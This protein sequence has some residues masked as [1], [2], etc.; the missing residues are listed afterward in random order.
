MIG[1][2][3]L[4]IAVVGLLAV[5]IIC[6]SV[7]CDRGGTTSG[8][9]TG[10]AA[11]TVTSVEEQVRAVL[12]ENPLYEQ[13]GGDSMD[14]VNPQTWRGPDGRNR[15]VFAR[16]VLPQAE[17]ATGPWRYLDCAGTHYSE[18]N[19]DFVNITGLTIVVDLERDEVVQFGPEWPETG[20][21]RGGLRP[22]D[23][24][25]D[26]YSGLYDILTGEPRADCPPGTEG[27]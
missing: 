15:G 25:A 4:P 6:V 27:S 17:E 22:E 9:P 7:A 18:M 8:R 21:L 20:E 13:L 23:I 26:D 16:L 10:P 19:A 12:A 2:P 5:G 14:L 11:P 24:P 3:R 1:R